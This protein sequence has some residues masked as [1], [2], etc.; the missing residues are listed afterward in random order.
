MPDLFRNGLVRPRETP[1]AHPRALILAELSCHFD[2]RMGR[3]SDSGRQAAERRYKRATAGHAFGNRAQTYF[4]L[5]PNG[6]SFV[7]EVWSVQRL[8]IW[9][10]QL[11]ES[12]RNAKTKLSFQVGIPHEEATIVAIDITMNTRHS[13]SFPR[14][15]C[16]GCGEAAPYSP[17][18]ERRDGRTKCQG[19]NNYTHSGSIW[20]G[21]S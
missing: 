13:A 10:N 3:L 7:P 12:A 9:M 11:P 4:R 18:G 8:A 1:K 17:K 16:N 20:A 19:A 15:A 21:H 6:S 14:Q 2:D 5:S